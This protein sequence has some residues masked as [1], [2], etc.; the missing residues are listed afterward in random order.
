MEED[1]EE[2]DGVWTCGRLGATR[3]PI[4][5]LRSPTRRPADGGGEPGH[6]GVGLGGVC[7]VPF[8]FWAGPHFRN[9]P[10]FT[11]VLRIGAENAQNASR[12]NS[13]A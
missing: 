5:L 6:L 3:R 2:R 11:R 13:I 7:F 4:L 9:R 12:R 10:F 8:W 1:A